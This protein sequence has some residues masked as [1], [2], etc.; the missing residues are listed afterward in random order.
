MDIDMLSLS[1]HKFHAPQGRRRA[2]HPQAAYSC[3]RFMHGGAQ[4]RNQRGG[5]ENLASIVGMGEAIERATANIDRHNAE[6]SRGARPA[7]RPHPQ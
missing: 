5:T 1:G 7:D 2:L 6:L 3:Q 4:E